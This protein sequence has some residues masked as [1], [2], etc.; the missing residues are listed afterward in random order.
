[1]KYSVLSLSILISL[2]LLAGCNDDDNDHPAN[3]GAPGSSL[4]TDGKAQL[5]V[6]HAVAD[7]PD[8]NVRAN[9][10]TVLTGVPYAAA[11]ALI[12]V[13]PDTYSVAVDGILPNGTA[14]VIGPAEIKLSDDQITNVLAVNTLANIEPL[15]V[16]VPEISVAKDSVRLTV[17]HAAAA[18]P[19]VDVYVTAPAAGLSEPVGEF[20]FKQTLGP[21]TIPAGTYR[22]RVTL[23][24]S[25]RIVFDSGASGLPLAGGSD[26]FLAAIE[27]TG[28]G[29]S[30]IELLVA[31][32]KAS[33]LIQDSATPADLKVVHAAPSVGAAEV[34]VSSPSLNLANVE[35][36]NS[37]N[38]LQQTPAEGSL[39]V[40]PA[41]D[42]QVAV[43]QDGTGIGAAL[44]NVGPVALKAGAEYTAIASGGSNGEAATL[45]LTQDDNRAIATEARVKVIHAAPDAG[46]VNIFVTPA[47]TV[48]TTQILNG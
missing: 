41:N 27:N 46:T 9:G 2:G 26:L 42:Y 22:I 36:I 39:G 47:D 15:V 19:A 21:V 5:R 31:D 37:L 3:N 24:N 28:P 11:S 40:R 13:M 35:L 6:F 32:G 14:T 44:I 4:A 12:G 25:D 1:M 7:A 33:S 30:P 16:T 38:Y 17:T 45:L 20:A 34:F 29:Q 48:S 18:A 10:G 43:A 8:V 23:P